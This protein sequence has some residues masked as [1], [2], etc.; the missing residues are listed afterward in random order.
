MV[1]SELDSEPSH[2][3]VRAG[4]A[5]PRIDLRLA[6]STASITRSTPAGVC[7]SAAFLRRRAAVATDE[8]QADGARRAP[9]RLRLGLTP[10]GLKRA[11][12]R[13]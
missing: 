4:A 11:G 10:N 3:G 13:R 8:G 12:E 1:R 7:R 5:G 2:E 9:R 6:G